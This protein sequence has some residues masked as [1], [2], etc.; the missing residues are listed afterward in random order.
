MNVELLPITAAVIQHLSISRRC[1]R[2]SIIPVSNV[3]PRH[4][5][6]DGPLV[7]MHSN[8]FES[9]GATYLLQLFAT[10]SSMVQGSLP[11][12]LLSHSL[13]PT[14]DHCATRSATISSV[15]TSALSCSRRSKFIITGGD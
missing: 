14:P 9:T 15:C 6:R 1:D 4:H 13:Q 11:F 7:D 12:G 5:L 3:D 8:A 10:F 2:P